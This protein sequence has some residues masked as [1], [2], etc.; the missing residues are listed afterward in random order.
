[1]TKS[2]VATYLRLEDEHFK[3]NKRSS[4]ESSIVLRTF[5]KL[6][7]I[8]D[9]EHLYEIFRSFR[10]KCLP[11]LQFQVSTFIRSLANKKRKSNLE[12]TSQHATV[13]SYTLYIK[14][15]KNLPK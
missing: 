7:K 10:P 5:V 3:R 9:M 1:M 14:T 6:G 11:N 13:F 15:I 8:K 12:K 4:A 2:Q